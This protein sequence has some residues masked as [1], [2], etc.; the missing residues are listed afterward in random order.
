MSLKVPKVKAP[1]TIHFSGGSNV[2]GEAFLS[3]QSPHRFGKENILDLL[4][5]ED[6]FFPLEA[7]TTSSI[8][9]IHKKSI[10]YI[11]THEENEERFPGKPVSVI[12]I[13]SDGEELA[14]DLTI[15][16]PSHRS[17]VLDFFNTSNGLFFKLEAKGKTYYINKQYVREVL[18]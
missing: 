1:L 6:F 18:P 10:V 2:M 5:N 9:L 3:P 17:R 12:I 14:G 16:G 7:E 11:T 8:R 15:E 4:N 13:R